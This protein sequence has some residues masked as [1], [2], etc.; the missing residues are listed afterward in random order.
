[1][2]RQIDRSIG[3]WGR[4]GFALGFYEWLSVQVWFL[5]YPK[6]VCE[7]M[8]HGQMERQIEQLSSCVSQGSDV[9]GLRMSEGVLCLGSTLRCLNG[10]Y[11]GF[12]TSFGLEC[13]YYGN[14]IYV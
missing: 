10:V 2:D 6:Y 8:P 1:M 14:R 12:H 11:E 7:G 13:G 9:A 5:G 4:A 3:H